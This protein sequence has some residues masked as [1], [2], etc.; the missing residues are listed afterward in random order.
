MQKMWCLYINQHT[1]TN[2]LYIGKT[3]NLQ[4]RLQEHN[5]GRQAAT[6]RQSGEWIIIYAEAYRGKEDADERETML[7]HHGSSKRKLYDRM[8]RSF[9]T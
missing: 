8:K 9:L 7:K 3:E 1:A 6:H 4:R 5:A 2:D